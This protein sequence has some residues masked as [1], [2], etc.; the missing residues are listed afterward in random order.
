MSG[1]GESDDSTTIRR[2]IL[3]SPT[4]PPLGYVDHDGSPL[5]NL[6]GQVRPQN[7]SPPYLFRLSY[8]T[9]P[10]TER[11]LTA[12]SRRNQE[13]HLFYC[14]VAIIPLS[15]LRIALTSRSSSNWQLIASKRIPGMDTF[16]VPTST[17]D[18][19]TKSH[20]RGY[21]T[22]QTFSPRRALSIPFPPKAPR[23]FLILL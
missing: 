22:V 19:L 5:A 2:K 9:V 15:A 7:T 3:L 17:T 10:R 12:K 13:T 18:P 6:I 21:W 8:W 16:Y 4:I 14:S 20:L 1:D 11:R 23:R